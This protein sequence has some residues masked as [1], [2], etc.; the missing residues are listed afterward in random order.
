MQQERLGFA[1]YDLLEDLNRKIAL[2]QDHLYKQS[3]SEVKQTTS[4]STSKAV[5][6]R[7]MLNYT[8]LL[9]KSLNFS[10]CNSMVT[11]DSV[12]HKQYQL[13]VPSNLELKNLIPKSCLENVVRVEKSTFELNGQ[14]FY[15]L[16]DAEGNT[17]VSQASG[18]SWTSGF[19]G[20]SVYG[21]RFC[22]SL[23]V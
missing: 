8:P 17:F 20:K 16:R 21:L 5:H 14:R 11:Q 12:K 2:I 7:S 15:F 4:A 19:I 13:I 22:L 10:P 6:S 9:S 3:M 18:D 1:L 23:L